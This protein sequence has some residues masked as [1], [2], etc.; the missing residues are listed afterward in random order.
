MVCTFFVH[1]DTPQNILPVLRTV[2][3]DLI[4]NKN[5]DLFYVGNNGNFDF[6]VKNTLKILKSSYPHIKYTIV[7][8]YMPNPKNNSADLDYCDTIYP[9]ELENTPRKY[10]IVKRNQWM[11]K[12]SDYVITYVKYATGGAVKFKELAEKQKKIVLNLG[13]LI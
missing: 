11:I 5:V 10:A 3:I 8:A 13:A 1:K 6:M 9:E 7:L 12:Q 2:I 4:Q